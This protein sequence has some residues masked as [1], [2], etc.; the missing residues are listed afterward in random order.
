MAK[1]WIWDRAKWLTTAELLDRSWARQWF[2]PLLGE[3]H[4]LGPYKLWPRETALA[5]ERHPILLEARAQLD[6]MARGARYTSPEQEKRALL[7]AI[8]RFDAGE[9]ASA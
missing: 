3:P 9:L 5:I 1:T 8:Q 6:V 2:E 7:V 4:K